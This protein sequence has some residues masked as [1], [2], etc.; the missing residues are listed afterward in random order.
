MVAMESMLHHYGLYH[1]GHVFAGVERALGHFVDLL[2][3]YD[4][5]GIFF[6]VEKAADGLRPDDVAHV[7]QAVHLYAVVQHAALALVVVQ[8]L[9]GVGEGYDRLVDGF[10][11][12]DEMFVARV[13]LVKPHAVGDGVDQVQHVVERIGQRVDVFAVQRG[14]ESAVQHIHYLVAQRVA[15]VLVVPDLLDHLFVY[16]ALFHGGFKVLH[17]LDGV[18]GLQG[19]VV[20]EFDFF[21][22]QVKGHLRAPLN[23]AAN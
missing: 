17:R 16:N 5:D 19:Q 9:H 7:L 23:A 21:G 18:L 15:F 22:D 13:Q 20:E 1:L 8:V 11:E 14:D 4:H 12:L 10:H 3:L 6:R 2:P